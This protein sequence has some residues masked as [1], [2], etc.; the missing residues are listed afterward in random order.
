M[1]RKE[2]IQ[3]EGMFYS[4]STEQA[5]CMQRVDMKN[6]KIFEFECVEQQSEE[7]RESKAAEAPK[8]SRNQD[9]II[10]DGPAQSKA[11]IPGH[12]NKTLEEAQRMHTCTVIRVQK[13]STTN[14][15]DDHSHKRQ[16]TQINQL[17]GGAPAPQEQS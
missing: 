6:K 1:E 4:Y 7:C 12:I 8:I 3:N 15:T 14:Q 10:E 5:S 16:C 2:Q 17:G 13:A 11:R 9:R